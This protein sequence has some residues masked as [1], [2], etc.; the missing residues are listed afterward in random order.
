[1]VVVRRALLSCSD[2]TGLPEFAGALGEL[3]VELVA[4]GGTA[5]ALRTHRLRVRTVEEFAGITEQLD[6]RVKTLHPKIHAGIL[7]RRDV[8]GHVQSVGP[9]GFIDLVVVNLYPFQQVIERTGVSRAEAIEQIDIGGV[10]L[11]RAAAKNAEHVGVV[12]HSQQYPKVAEALRSGDGQLST[13]Y[14]AELA[15]AAFELTSAYDAA[16]AGFLAGG[17]P[18]GVPESASLSVCR[19]QKLRYGE[20]PHQQAAWYVQASG[21]LEALGTLKQLQGKELSYNNLLDLDAALRCLAEGGSSEEAM[22]MCVIMKHA[23]PCGLASGASAAEA[24]LRAHACDTESAFGGIVGLNRPVDL[25]TAKAMG[26]KFLEVVLAPRVEPDAKPILATKANLRVVTV[27]WPQAPRRGL[28]WR[29]LFGSWLLQ[30]TDVTDVDLDAWRLATRRAPTAQERED[31]R[32]AWRVVAALRS[33]GVVMVKQQATVGIGQGQ[34]SR[35]GAARLAVAHSGER[36]KGAVAASDGFFPFADGVEL[37]AKAGV[38]AVV[39]PGGSIRDPEVVAAADAAGMVMLVT[40]TRH[41]R[42]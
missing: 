14:A 29:Q 36:A 7:A 27:D 15:V 25:A 37:L 1:M 13:E 31:L 40:G 17:P 22:A 21:P 4:S 28:E 5:E 8:Q 41:F 11:L 32:F 18:A 34:P 19:R 35:V 30:Q 39:Q 24:F 9:D 3:G 10:A 42:H 12:C 33:N 38:T 20:N 23:M 26:S 16:I 6:G 2:K